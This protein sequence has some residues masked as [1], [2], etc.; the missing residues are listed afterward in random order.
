V[1]LT[2]SLLLL[3]TNNNQIYVANPHTDYSLETLVDETI[4]RESIKRQCK[5]KVCEDTD[6]DS[7]KNLSQCDMCGSFVCSDCVDVD[8]C[9]CC[10]EKKS[11]II[12]RFN[13]ALIR[14]VESL[15]ARAV[16]NSH[17]RP[18]STLWDQPITSEEESEQS[19]HN[20]PSL[21]S[22]S[23]QSV[24]VDSSSS[25]KNE[26]LST[27]SKESHLITQ[28]SSQASEQVGQLKT[29]PE[30]LVAKSRLTCIAI[31]KR[32]EE[33]LLGQQV[34]FYLQN[35][36]ELLEVNTYPSLNA[37][38]I[39]L[40]VTI[41]SGSCSTSILLR[42]KPFYDMLEKSGITKHLSNIQIDVLSV[43]EFVRRK[44]LRADITSQLN[45][46]GYR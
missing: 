35:N 1:R 3:G 44:K 19:P 33:C 16:S 45:S 20:S 29:P 5:A 10:E 13:L 34:L 23:G 46:G 12:T 14:S 6:C 15:A 25:G 24:G 7:T 30:D 38:L 40:R 37:G 41:V 39:N 18:A 4:W 36:K 22:L 17:E 9:E 42:G 8:Q 43:K 2:C 11:L 28:T 32:V 27:T 31:R 21:T 26:T